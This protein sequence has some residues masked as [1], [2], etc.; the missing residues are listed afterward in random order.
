[1]KIK[2][3]FLK[4]YVQVVRDTPDLDWGKYLNEDDWKIVRGVVVP[5]SWYPAETMGRIGR[6]IYVMRANSDYKLVRLHGRTRV[7]QFFDDA[8][9]QLLSI[10]S[11][12][13]ALQAYAVITRRYIDEVDIN[14]EK[15]GDNFAELSFFPVDDAPGWDLFREIQAGT[16]ERVVE[17]N[18]AKDPR[19]LFRA[20]TRGGR[21]A[22]IVK[23]EWK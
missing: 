6:G 16:M 7:D 21:E 1:M 5:L 23:L 13:Q 11:P 14:L 15:S 9:R 18:G 20:E 22:C 8:T 2:G 10:N 3:N 19:A 4:D 12:T 17:L